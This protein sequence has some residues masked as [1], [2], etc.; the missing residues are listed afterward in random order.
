M[1]T[2]MTICHDTMSYGSSI[3]NTNNIQYT[4]DVTYS[5]SII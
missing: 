4:I 1:Y 3:N 2:T 5:N